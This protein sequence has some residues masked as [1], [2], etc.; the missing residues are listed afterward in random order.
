M[1]NSENQQARF[2][3]AMGAAKL[4][5]ENGG[6]MTDVKKLK[7]LKKRLLEQGKVEMASDIQSVIDD[8]ACKRELPVDRWIGVGQ[9]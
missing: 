5:N 9:R 6:N 4:R 3:V 2:S 7:D 8:Y 1:R